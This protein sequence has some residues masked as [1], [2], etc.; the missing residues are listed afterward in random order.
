[1]KNT[2]KFA[3]M[4]AALTLSACSVAP[5]FSFAVE[6]TELSEEAQTAYN[7]YVE[8]NEDITV[9]EWLALDGNEQYIPSA[10][11][12][13]PSTETEVTL[14]AGKI[15]FKG[16]TAGI[17][18]YSVYKIFAGTADANGMNPEIGAKLN[19]ITWADGISVTVQNAL[20]SE[21]KAKGTA[22]EVTIDV[23]GTETTVNAFDSLPETAISAVDFSAAVSK[24][25]STQAKIFADTVVR[26]FKQN[27]VTAIANGTGAGIELTEDGYYVIAETGI[28][29]TGAG[30]YEGMT[31]YLLG[32][33]DASAGAVVTVKSD[34]P[35]FQK[36][37]KDINDSTGVE[38]GWQDSADYDI[39]D[40]VPFQLKAT[41]PSNYNEY[42]AYKL[43]FH[44][45]FRN[46]DGEEVFD[47][48]EITALYVDANNNGV[49]D[50]GDVDL[51]EKYSNTAS[52]VDGYDFDVII[53]DLKKD[54]EKLSVDEN[55]KD[56]LANVIVEYTAILNENAVIGS[57]GNWND[58]YLSYTTNPN[59]NGDGD[60]EE[61]EHPKDSPVDT[62]VVFTYQ[63]NIDKVNPQGTSLTGAHFTLAKK[64]ATAL[65]VE[66]NSQL[67]KVKVQLL[68]V[69]TM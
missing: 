37:L 14:E 48:D 1:M 63:T 16:E 39:G 34:V 20:V 33:Y 57:A 30:E 52:A 59:W 18:S 40:K 6:V 35:S 25:D 5:M 12:T 8:E 47:F 15:K 60:N 51:S 10:P 27:S 28:T 56:I 38:E 24:L 22:F 23:D 67:A 49:Y 61:E 50:D 13:P 55:N 36:K 9:D 4:I 45:N 53:A 2:K 17:H 43:A 54:F 26:V 31:T 69:V 62:T 64:Y 68:M 42:K 65:R 7:T 44:D 41:L 19:D 11:V 58:A 46:V 3:A 32:V 66:L 29:G 21:L